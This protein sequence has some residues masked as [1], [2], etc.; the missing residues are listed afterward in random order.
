LA[1]F[2]ILPQEAIELTPRLRPRAVRLMIALAFHMGPD[3]KCWPSRNTLLDLTGLS[4]KHFKEARKDLGKYGLEWVPQVPK[5]TKYYWPFFI[6]DGAPQ[7]A[8]YGCPTGAPYEGP[9]GPPK[10]DVRDPQQYMNRPGT[11]Q[12]QI[13]FKSA[14]QKTK[15]MRNILG[16]NGILK[17]GT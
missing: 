15:E 12:K 11:N 10:G 8:S 6:R 4:I 14:F 1:R 9:T 7:G 5:S 17:T 2:A 16:T 13:P 3:G